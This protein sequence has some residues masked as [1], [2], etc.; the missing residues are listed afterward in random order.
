MRVKSTKPTDHPQIFIRE[1]VCAKCGYI[2]VSEYVY[3][4]NESDYYYDSEIK[5]R[6]DRKEAMSAERSERAR[7][8]FGAHWKKAERNG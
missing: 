6:E 7:K 2:Q 4:R 3:P 8:N 5:D 1:Y